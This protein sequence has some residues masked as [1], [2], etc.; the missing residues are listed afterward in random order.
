MS[1]KSVG[2]AGLMAL[3]GLA[4]FA[5][6][7]ANPFTTQA[8]TD[9]SADSQSMQERLSADV[10]TPSQIAGPDQ[11]VQPQ[12]ADED[13]EDSEPYIGVA[14]IGLDDGSVQVVR[15]LEGGPSD[16]ALI[17]GD[18]I[19]GVDGT[20]ITGTNDLID[21]IVEPGSDTTITLTITRDGSS[22][23]VDVTV[24]ERDTTVP[25]VRVHRSSNTYAPFKS[26]QPR[27]GK[28]KSDAG[29]EVVHR[30]IVFENSDGSLQHIPSGHRHGVKCR[31]HGRNVHAQPEGRLRLYRLH[32]QR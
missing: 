9:D 29:G 22:Q 3:A 7:A 30:R 19:T 21:A 17:S 16:G 10:I 12:A 14:I 13:S 25:S 20:T 24:G 23:T 26:R 6:I 8:A 1:A 4:L 31:C 5:V 27:F 2:I 18:L 15:V 28:G 11:P 32:H